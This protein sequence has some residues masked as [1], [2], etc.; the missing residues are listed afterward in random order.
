MY[1]A[2]TP[3]L[4]KADAE[5]VGRFLARYAIQIAG[6][7]LY[8]ITEDGKRIEDNP[9]ADAIKETAMSGG[10]SAVMAEGMVAAGISFVLPPLAM[11]AAIAAI[12]PL[13]KKQNDLRKQNK[14]G[15]VGA[16]AVMSELQFDVT[17]VSA[18]RRK[19][20][21]YLLCIYAARH[22][23]QLRGLHYPEQLAVGARYAASHAGD[24]PPWGGGGADGTAPAPPAWAKD[25]GGPP[26]NA[27][28]GNLQGE[29]R[30]RGGLLRE[31]W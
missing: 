25:A 2:H 28:S 6:L 27:T 19:W 16:K 8:H 5:D 13:L 22:D 9:T 4:S 21:E 3:V 1:I 15:K 12:P 26:A 29:K 17:G 30:K 23:W 18:R 20:T 7:R 31:L 10:G 14:G 24:P 11:L